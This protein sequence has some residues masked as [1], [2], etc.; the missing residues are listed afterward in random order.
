[1]NI[2]IK[3]TGFIVELATVSLARNLQASV[4]LYPSRNIYLKISFDFTTPLT[5]AG[6]ARKRAKTPF[7]IAL[8]AFTC[9]GKYS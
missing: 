8:W 6:V 7:A 9:C 3:I 2:H 5:I 4:V 1:L